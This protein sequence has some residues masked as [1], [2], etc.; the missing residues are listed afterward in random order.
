MTTL[1]EKTHRYGIAFNLSAPLQQRRG[2]L[3]VIWRAQ[4]VALVLLTPLGLAGL[5]ESRFA[6]SSLLAVAAL[7]CLGTAFAFVAFPT[8]VGRVGS[9]R[10]SVTVCFLSAVAIVLG[11]VFGHETIAAASL[12]GTALVTAGVYLTSRAEAAGA[13]GAETENSSIIATTTA[14]ASQEAT[15]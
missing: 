4:I 12:L 7:G 5:R 3:S 11:A 15:L 1:T 9:T 2:V 13:S 8:L 14:V 10:A 6:W